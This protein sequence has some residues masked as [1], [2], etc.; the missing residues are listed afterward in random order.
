MKQKRIKK[1]KA[2]RP[3]RPSMRELARAL[4]RSPSHICRVVK[5]ERVSVSLS[6]QLNALGVE[7]A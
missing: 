2:A 3:E 5:G 4:H 1:I 6:R 7:V